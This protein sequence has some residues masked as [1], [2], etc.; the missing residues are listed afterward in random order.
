M[1]DDWTWT[2]DFWLEATT[3]PTEPYNHCPWGII[4]ALNI[5]FTILDH[6]FYA[7]LPSKDCIVKF[8]QACVVAIFAEAIIG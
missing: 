4:L 6:G 2:M 7:K 3:L 5:L 1:A 8:F